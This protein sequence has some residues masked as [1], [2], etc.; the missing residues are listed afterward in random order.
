M[1]MVAVGRGVGFGVVVEVAILSCLISVVVKERG[2]GLE[3]GVFFFFRMVYL[4]L[5]VAKVLNGGLRNQFDDSR[6]KGS[7]QDQ[8]Q[9]QRLLKAKCKVVTWEEEKRIGEI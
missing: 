3:R 9:E 4:V 7:F 1:V 8:D 5:E 2:G 6:R